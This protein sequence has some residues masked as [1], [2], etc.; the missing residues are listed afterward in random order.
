MKQKRFSCDKC[1]KKFS[2][3][4][5]SQQHINSV[6]LKQKP[7]SCGT[8]EKYYST[9]AILKKHI[10]FVHLK[11]KLFTSTQCKSALS[12]KDKL[13][14][15]VRTVH[16]KQKPF[17]CNDCNLKFSDKYNLCRHKKKLHEPV[18]FFMW[19]Q[20]R[21][22]S[23]SVIFLAK[24]HCSISPVFIA[25]SPMLNFRHIFRPFICDFGTSFYFSITISVFPTSENR[26]ILKLKLNGQHFPKID[27]Q[28]LKFK[29]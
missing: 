2:N 15:H 4:S 24:Y 14:R 12:Q 13:Q 5:D 18:K 10:N 1:R 29:S 27:G 9:Q 21:P 7:F 16:L 26:L 25:K 23:I 3:R 11:L 17:S 19:S 22:C 6:H 20:N 8:C 28:N